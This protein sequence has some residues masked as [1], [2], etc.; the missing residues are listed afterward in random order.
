M[1]VRA[2]EPM[3]DIIFRM[4]DGSSLCGGCKRDADTKALKNESL[5]GY[6][7]R[8]DGCGA[9]YVQAD[10]DESAFGEATWGWVKQNGLDA[11]KEAVADESDI[12]T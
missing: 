1:R 2:R 5:S 11:M 10:F 8:C 4:P 7:A 6:A 12:P 9:K 3:T